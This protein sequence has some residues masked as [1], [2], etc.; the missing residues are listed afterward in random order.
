M[1]TSFTVGAATITR[2]EET[3]EPNFDATEFFPDLRP[4]GS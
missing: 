3:Y 1:M 4:H 2:I